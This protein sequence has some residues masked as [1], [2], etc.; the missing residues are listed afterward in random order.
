MR[1]RQQDS[2]L[3]G[4]IL[5]SLLLH[6]VAAYQLPL[7]RLLEAPERPREPMVVEMLP[8]EEPVP[9]PRPKP[10]ELELPESAPQE[11]ETPAERLGPQDHVAKE[12]VAPK[13]E[14]FEDRTPVTPQRKRV[15]PQRTPPP[16]AAV[17][18]VPQAP[19]P[20]DIPLPAAPIPL[21]SLMKLPQETIDRSAREARRKER[22]GVK[23]GDVVWLDT[24]KD[25]LA[26]FFKRFK[27]NIYRVWDYPFASAQRGEQGVSRLQIT[28][29]RQGVV[30]K[31]DVLMGSGSAALDREAVKA[32]R[33]G[34]PYGPL[35]REY[36]EETLKIVADFHYVLS[37]RSKSLG[38]WGYRQS[39]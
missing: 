20:A 33:M 18:T 34:S 15:M 32:V 12:E 39:I 23:E 8:A 38:R 17:P 30:K 13:G 4:F 27:D 11:R 24:E 2:L 1:T 5:L 3:F 37:G 19:K 25:I 10:R 35:P 26:S 22:E 28:V 6:L 29:N 31:V 9:S 7:Q 16:V 21:D 14:D 36:K